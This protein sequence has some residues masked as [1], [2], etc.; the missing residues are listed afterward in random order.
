MKTCPACKYQRGTDWSIKPSVEIGD[1][2]FIEIIGAF[3]VRNDN[4]YNGDHE[5]ELYA[6]PKCGCVHMIDDQL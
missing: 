3:R 6:C 5:I 2:E 1:V 4:H